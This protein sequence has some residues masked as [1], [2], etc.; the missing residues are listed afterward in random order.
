MSFRGSRILLGLSLVLFV[1]HAFALIGHYELFSRGR[2]PAARK[3]LP[4]QEVFAV[5]L[6]LLVAAGFLAV[7]LLTSA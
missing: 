4:Q 1:G 5:V 3:W 7:A 6:T 2:R